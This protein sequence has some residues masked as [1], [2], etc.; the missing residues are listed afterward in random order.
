M[1]ADS[2]AAVPRCARLAPAQSPVEM[3][4]PLLC[5]CQF[6]R[7]AFG[8]E[9]PLVT[10]GRGGRRLHRNRTTVIAT[11]SASDAGSNPDLIMHYDVW[12][13]SSLS[14]LAT[15]GFFEGCARPRTQETPHS[16]E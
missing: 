15:T 4:T 11:A 9:L 13:A 1:L 3:R 12:I 14:L 2:N 7:H 6:L 8:I 5:S 16:K 10:G